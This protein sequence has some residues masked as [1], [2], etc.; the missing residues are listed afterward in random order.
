[1]T[2]VH[3]AAMG[4]SRHS[5]YGFD[6]ENRLVYTGISEKGEPSTL[7]AVDAETAERT[8]LSSNANVEPGRFLF[9]AD[10]KELLG[11]NYLDGYPEIDFIN[12]S[13]PEVLTYASLMNAFPDHAVRF[14]G[15]SRD[16]RYVLARVY[17][18]VDPGSY[19][20]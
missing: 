11:V 8:K 4:D 7:Y 20:L 10:G 18:D 13:H 17:S 2:E 15:M 14:D 16:G 9:S 6:R 19:Y 5:P 1:W 3:R 12:K